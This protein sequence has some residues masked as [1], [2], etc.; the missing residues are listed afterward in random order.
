MTKFFES[1]PKKDAAASLVADAR[2]HS[3][4]DS[5]RIDRD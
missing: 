4:V 1:F 2:K 3:F 5:D